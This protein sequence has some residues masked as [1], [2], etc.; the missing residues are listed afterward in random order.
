MSHSFPGQGRHPPWEADWAVAQEAALPAKT[1]VG[2]GSGEDEEAQPRNP[3][4]GLLSSGRDLRQ[5]L[6][7]RGSSGRTQT[8]THNVAAHTFSAQ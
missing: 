4:L 3:A 6:T 7:A 5:L 2:E 8:H 1:G